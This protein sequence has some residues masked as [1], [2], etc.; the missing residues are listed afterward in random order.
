MRRPR[1]SEDFRE[2]IRVKTFSESERILRPFKPSGDIG[3]ALVFPNS[4]EV[5]SSSLSFSFVRDLLSSHPRLH[6]ERFFFEEDFRR[7]YSLESFKPLDE[8]KIWAF[9]VNFELDVL[10]VLEI[11]HRRSIPLRWRDRGEDQPL[12]LVGGALTYFNAT[13][14]WEVADLIYHGDLEEFLPEFL[15]ALTGESKRRILEKSR[16]IPSLSIPALSKEGIVA[17]VRDINTIPPVSSFTSP[18]GEFKDMVLI[19]V[20]R[21]CI[22]RCSF[23]MVGHVQ[24]P[25]RFMRPDTLERILRDLPRDAKLGL[26]SATITDYPW[27]DEL[28]NLLKD[29]KFSVSSMRM[30]GITLDLL[31]SLR[32]SGQ[33]SF[34]V[35]PE[36]GSQKIRD[37]LRKDI[38]EEDIEKSLDLGLKAGFRDVKMYFIYGLDEEDEED[39]KGIADVAKTAREMGY[40]VKLSLNPLIPKPMTPFQDRKLQPPRV[41]RKKEA[42]LRDIFRKEGLRYDFESLRESAVQWVIANATPEF[43]RVIVE[44][45]ERTGKRGLFKYLLSVASEKSDER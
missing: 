1:R 2:Y 12:I 8:F 3:V 11:L 10:N 28:L 20:G 19:E 33:R 44:E 17:K 41:L 22:R 27:L 42:L 15:E 35:A 40:K 36:G 16:E 26:I 6:V 45:F 5:A 31:R 4:Y 34:T 23:C 24:K 25:A 43:S 39:L 21:G 38:T 29:R 14:L 13:S 30:D 32:R 37:I 7:F 18:K 9:S